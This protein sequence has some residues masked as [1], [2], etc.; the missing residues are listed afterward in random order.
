VETTAPSA[1]EGVKQAS[2]HLR[3]TLATEL[4][5]G[6]ER[7]SNDST[8]L[9][10]FHGIYQQDDRD[11]RRSRTQAKQELAYS[12]MVRT[13]VPGGA[14]TADQWLAMD[15]LTDEVGN[16][17]LRI[18][19]RQGIQFHFTAKS[20]LRTLVHTLN[21]HLVT[22]LGACGD[23]VRNVTS[24]PAPLADGRQDGLLEHARA[25]A[26]RLRPRTDAYYELWID[27]DKAVT[28][29]PAAPASDGEEPLYG[30]SYLPRKFKVGLAWP[31]DNCIDVYS[32]DVGIVPVPEAGRF[33]VLVGGGLGMSHAREDDT[34][35]RLAEPLGSVAPERLGDVV[36]A[37][38]VVQRDHGNRADRHRARLKYLIDERGIDWFRAEVEHLLG[39][40]LEDPLALPPWTGA[41]D[42]LGWHAQPDGRWFLGVHVADGR[43][44]DSEGCR[45]RSAL[46]EIVGR[47]SPGLRL[48][49]RQDVLFTDLDEADR[50]AVD[51]VLRDHGVGRAEELAPLRR[52]G[53]A[54]PALPTCGQ[55]LTEAERVMPAV[56]DHLQG[57]LEEVGLD[58]SS[59]HVN[60][61][62]CPNG[63]ARPYTAE[64]GIVGRTK[65]GYDVYA[66]GSQTGTRLARRVA[67][68]VKTD[69]IGGVLR[70]ALTRWRD[71]GEPGEGFGD[72]CE[73][74]GWTGS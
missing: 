8:T 21:Q 43:V 22:T 28:A 47:F 60:M 24:C 69:E 42:H 17:T 33:V 11:V 12:C 46:R 40:R 63:C 36:E 13:S 45:Q 25:L 68:N 32:H 50:T 53:L 34:Y 49:A 57:T 30:D 55:A 15:R 18:T 27:G 19:T 23:V 65:R 74:V 66:G 59:F 1:A 67:V 16:G 6:S 70:P 62:G 26:A 14:L 4:G 38:V 61:T 54:C 37:V 73:R 20:D 31:G 64:V 51:G 72:F 3:G 56:L 71:E 9:L 29:S 2:A 39:W 44:R 5:D 48:T 35:P 52:H 41:D 58:G 10:K 7:F